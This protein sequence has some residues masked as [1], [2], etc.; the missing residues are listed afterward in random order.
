[1]E[2]MSGAIKESLNSEVSIEMKEGSCYSPQQV[3]GPGMRRLTGYLG[4]SDHKPVNISWC[5]Y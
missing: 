5:K 4:I 2:K 3:S 1:M